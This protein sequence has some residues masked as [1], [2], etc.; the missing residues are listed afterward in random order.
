VNASRLSVSCVV[1]SGLVNHPCNR[2]EGCLDVCGSG[3]EEEGVR[4]SREGRVY[5]GS[6]QLSSRGNDDAEHGDGMSSEEDVQ[7]SQNRVYFGSNRVYLGSSSGG[8]D[9]ADRD[10]GHYGDDDDEEGDEE[11]VRAV[12]LRYNAGLI[13]LFDALMEER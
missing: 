12:L 8:S 11:R 13:P 2:H 9:G 10:G 5:F 7:E 3:D 4:G 1:K 6:G